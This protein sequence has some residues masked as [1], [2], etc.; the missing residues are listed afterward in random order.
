MMLKFSAISNE[1]MEE[2]SIIANF[3]NNSTINLSCWTDDIFKIVGYFQSSLC[4]TYAELAYFSVSSLLKVN[5]VS[6]GFFL[7]FF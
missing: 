3:K 6:E 2:T 1:E 7:C 4:I 5:K